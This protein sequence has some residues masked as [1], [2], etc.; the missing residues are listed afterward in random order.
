MYNA[1]CYTRPKVLFSFLIR[2]QGNLVVSRSPMRMLLQLMMASLG[3]ILCH[4]ITSIHG[5]IPCFVCCFEGSLAAFLPVLGLR[6]T[7]HRVACWI[8]GISDLILKA[9]DLKSVLHFWE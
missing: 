3:R 8:I 2:E 1:P 7:L 9:H 6:Q 5:P 4:F